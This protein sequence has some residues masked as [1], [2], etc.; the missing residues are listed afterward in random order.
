[1]ERQKDIKFF[2]SCTWFITLLMVVA[3]G[4]RCS[5]GRGSGISQTFMV[6]NNPRGIAIDACGNI[7]FQII[8]VTLLLN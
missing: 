3:G 1:M 5:G 6:G 2:L 7:W 8:Q 4:L